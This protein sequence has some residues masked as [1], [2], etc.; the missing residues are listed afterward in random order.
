MFVRE[1]VSIQKQWFRTADGTTYTVDVENRTIEGGPRCP[2]P[3]KYARIDAEI[4]RPA[5]VILENGEF[6]STPTVTDKQGNEFESVY[7][8][9][10]RNSAYIVDL[11]RS[12]ISGGKLGEPVRFVNQPV[13]VAG[14]PATFLLEDGREMVTSQVFSVRKAER[15]SN[16]ELSTPNI[17]RTM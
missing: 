12:I 11:D 10:T 15:L 5:F 6:F 9:K 2:F 3:K 17:E 7:E 8:I 13:I 1:P 4:R 16:M 14:R